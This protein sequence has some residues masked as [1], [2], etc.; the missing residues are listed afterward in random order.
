MQ[1]NAKIFLAAYM[2]AGRP[3]H[4]FETVQDL[5]KEVMRVSEPMLV[6]VHQVSCSIS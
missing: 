2:I 4:V 1:V 3:C 5:E 6:C